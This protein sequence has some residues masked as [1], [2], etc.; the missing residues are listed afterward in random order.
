MKT[1]WYCCKCAYDGCGGTSLELHPACISCGEVRCSE[2]EVESTFGGK[3]GRK[4]SL[5][6][7][8]KRKR[9]ATQIEALPKD[10]HGYGALREISQPFTNRSNRASSLQGGS[11]VGPGPFDY[12]ASI[13]ETP[14][15]FPES[16]SISNYSHGSTEQLHRSELETSWPNQPLENGE[17][18]PRECPDD[19]N[20]MPYDDRLMLCSTTLSTEVF[21]V[22]EING[23]SQQFQWN[24][25]MD[26]NVPTTSAI[27]PDFPTLSN[28]DIIPHCDAPYQSSATE[29]VDCFPQSP[30]C[31]EG[32]DQPIIEKRKPP[33]GMIACQVCSSMSDHDSK[34]LACHFFKLDPKKYFT[35]N[36]KRFMSINHARQHIKKDHCK[37]CW[38][39]NSDED[40]KT[41]EEC[42]RI[43]N[44]VT[45]NDLPPISKAQGIDP[46]MKWYWTW[47]DLFGEEAFS[48]QCPYSHP[49][50]DVLNNAFCMLFWRLEM[51]GDTHFTLTQ[52]QEMC[53]DLI[54]QTMMQNQLV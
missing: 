17:C 1:V 30:L 24:N 12:S 10:Q 7:K 46:T 42:Q 5:Y 43:M 23:G 45:S 31:H 54:G 20:T 15:T 11:T 16:L 32:T 14:T 35:C 39:L 4:G 53:S 38:G 51:T 3:A 40:P 25:S 47:R 48:P 13:K 22:G 28:D 19:I 26:G 8:S 41:H 37:Y 27:F 50:Q 44:G 2:C 33:Q 34:S 9:V 18:T 6:P 29:L 52:I 49:V 36:G 21:D